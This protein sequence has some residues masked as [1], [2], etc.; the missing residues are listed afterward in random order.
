MSEKFYLPLRGSE[1]YIYLGIGIKS[2]NL[3]KSIKRDKIPN[4]CK[5][6]KC[7]YW[8]RKK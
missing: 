6:K 1:K 2:I 5:L 4:L 7:I 8:T 3:Y